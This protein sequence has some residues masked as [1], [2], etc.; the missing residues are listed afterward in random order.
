MNLK[1][2]S[3]GSK[4]FLLNLRN[5]TQVYLGILICLCVLAVAMPVLSFAQNEVIRVKEDMASAYLKPDSSSRIV[6]QFPMGAMLESKQ[7]VGEWFEISYNDDSGFTISAYI[8]SS[9]VEV[10]SGVSVPPP[11]KSQEQEPQSAPA[12]H[13]LTGRVPSGFFLKM[14][15]DANGYGHW[16]GSIGFDFR[17]F[18]YVA[19]GIE[20]MPSFTSLS[21]DDVGLDQTTTSALTYLNIKAGTSLHFIKPQMDFIKVF[22]GWGGGLALS[23]T[24]ATY[25]GTTSNLFKTDPSMHI[26][27]GFELDAGKV[28]LIFEYNRRRILDPDVD[29]D[30]CLEYI[31]FGI[32]F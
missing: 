4:N 17:L 2:K 24:K 27:A 19:L 8:P 29:P 14:G 26:I 9:T 3:L 7:R 25:E 13:T 6:R 30:A 21:N 15:V 16:I 28:S 10:V 22:G 31:M 5:G 1:N 32:R 23:N 11:T 12:S 18:K 20:V